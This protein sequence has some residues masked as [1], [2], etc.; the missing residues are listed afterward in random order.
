ME[1]QQKIL[2]IFFPKGIFEWFDLVNG[3]IEGEDIKI[4]LKEKDIPP[5]DEK[6]NQKI[7]ARKFHD[8]TITDFPVRG[9]RTLLTLRR[10]YWKVEGKQ[11]Y[12]KRDIQLSFLG[13]QLEKEFANF[14][15]E[16]G[17]RGTILANFY[18]KISAHPDQ[19]V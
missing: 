16:D 4:T 3:T 10:R 5:I 15:K 1:I 9:R 14:L 19:R 2:E 18:R 6:S 12:L 11:E 8:I 13:T 7:I 17:G